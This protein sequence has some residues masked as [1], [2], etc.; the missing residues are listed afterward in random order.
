[1]ADVIILGSR[2][3]L[4]VELS[5]RIDGARQYSHQDIDIT[6]LKQL[7]LV[8]ID[9]DSLVINAAAYTNVNLA[10]I[11][12]EAAWKV[13]ANASANLAIWTQEAGA[14]LINISTDYVFNKDYRDSGKYG[15]ILSSE[16]PNPISTYGISK[17]AGELAT[18]LNPRSYNIRTTCVY[19]SG[20]NFVRTVLRLAKEAGT[21][22]MI[23]DQLTRPTW[24]GDLAEFIIALTTRGDHQ[25]GTYHYTNSGEVVSWFELANYIVMQAKVEAK[26]LPIGTKQYIEM[27]A[28][29]VIAPR[30]K[31]AILDIN[32]ESKIYDADWKD[33]LRAY[34]KAELKK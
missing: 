14:R 17:A 12:Q 32:K 21:L 10:E 9:Q 31:Y 6:D 2:G 1:M 24:A 34:L 28:D 11:E 27:Q 33:S 25:F 15:G 5:L 7:R 29:Q 26:V 8:R 19:G 16:T 30:P 20:N 18:T 3:Q 23:N 22:K 4:G 13:N